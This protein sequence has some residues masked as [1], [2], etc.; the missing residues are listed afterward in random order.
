MT[1]VQVG[2]V[3][4]GDDGRVCVGD[5]ALWKIKDNR[6]VQRLKLVQYVIDIVEEVVAKVRPEKNHSKVCVLF[7]CSAVYFHSCA[8][9]LLMSG[10]HHAAYPMR[11]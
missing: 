5:L 11:D 3:S 2:V 10:F 7:S 8:L 4:V 6:S 1:M 9:V